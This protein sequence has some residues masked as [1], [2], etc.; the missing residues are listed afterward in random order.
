MKSAVFSLQQ[1]VKQ[2]FDLFKGTVPAQASAA[3]ASMD[4]GGTERGGA[5][6]RP[7]VNQSLFGQ[8]Y[9]EEARRS[10]NPPFGSGQSGPGEFNSSSAG[11]L[12]LLSKTEKWL[13]GLPKAGHES[14]RD[15]DAEIV[16]YHDYLVEL[17]SWASLVNPRF[18]AE[19]AEA[20]SSGTEIILYV[21]T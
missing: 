6:H 9:G 10:P 5:F 14:W 2:L 4:A 12:D 8:Q 15:R 20:A 21:V 19:I 1:G 13:P 3:A 7:G 17:R 16:G 18:A 11:G